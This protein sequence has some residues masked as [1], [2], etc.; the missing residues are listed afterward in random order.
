LHG[1]F[2]VG[3]S[4]VVVSGWMRLSYAT[5]R[6]L[7]RLRL[8]PSTVTAV[9]LVLSL[10]VPLVVL[11]RGVWLFAAAGLVFLSALADSSDGAVAIMTGRTSGIGSFYDSLADRMSEAAWLLALWLLGAPGLLVAACGG[12][13]WLHEYARARAALAGM[14]GVGAVTVAERP[15]RV[16][17][18]IAA[19]V[20][21]GL[22]W[23]VSPRLTPGLITVIVSVWLVLGLLGA[24]RLLTAI[25]ASLH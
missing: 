22:V 7:A 14:P 6:L 20:A 19:L 23:F 15:T 11:P 1:G 18:V 10:A 17:L 12:L 21:G 3:G 9:G 2:D 5:G 25:R 16:L 13:A 8:S 24:S 4:Q